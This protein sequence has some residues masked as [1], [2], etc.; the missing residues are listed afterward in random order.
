VITVESDQSG[1]R[2][3]DTAVEAVK[4]TGA[5]VSGRKRVNGKGEKSVRQRKQRNG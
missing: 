3:V 2:A 5:T 1:E 4:L